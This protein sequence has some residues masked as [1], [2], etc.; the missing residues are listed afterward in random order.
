MSP[1]LAST[2][3]Y[4]GR[5]P[6]IPDSSAGVTGVCLVYAALEN[7]IQDCA[8]WA[9]TLTAETHPLSHSLDFC[10]FEFFFPVSAVLHWEH[11]SAEGFHDSF[12][13]STKGRTTFTTH[14]LGA[15]QVHLV[16]SLPKVAPPPSPSCSPS[17]TNILSTNPHSSFK[18]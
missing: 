13:S 18:M 1:S 2:S 15:P 6:G 4:S 10:S 14:T 11:A 5:W 9:S 3:L 8:G 7:P 16:M 17:H 12:M